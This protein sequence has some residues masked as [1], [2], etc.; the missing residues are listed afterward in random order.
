M[1]RPAAT[2]TTAARLGMTPV[3]G[4]PVPGQWRRMYNAIL[5]REDDDIKITGTGPPP[6]AVPGAENP[7]WCEAEI[8]VD[9]VPLA[10]YSVHLPAR[11]AVE[12]L[13]QAQRLANVIAQSGKLA[14]VGGDGNSIPRTDKPGED[15]LAAM[16]PHL[17]PAR[18]V[19]DGGPLR[20]DYSVD[21]TFTGAGLVDLAAFL[22]PGRRVPAEL[23]PTGRA[24]SRV[25]RH[26]ATPELAAAAIGYWQLITG[27]TDHHMTM[28]IYDRAVLALAAPPGPRD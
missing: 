14:H 24:G 20:P 4:P 22:P 25:D 7:A 11:T 27:G 10:L 2:C 18:M 16:S 17:R 23:L 12:Q 28:T 15:E 26:Y 19:L 3:L 1:T 9:G 8:T 5:V 21:D 6:M 13:R